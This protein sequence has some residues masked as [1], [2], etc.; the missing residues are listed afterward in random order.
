[1]NWR[2]GRYFVPPTDIIELTDRL[3]VMI[4]IA[5]M[6]SDDF[7][8]TQ[9]NRTLIVSGVRRRDISEFTTYHQLEIGYGY[10]RVEVNLPWLPDAEQI[11]ATYRDGI[12]EVALPRRADRQIPVVDVGAKEGLDGTA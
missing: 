7:N 6:S 12:L 11:E 8:I 9:V 1:M 2:T 3:L 5:G 10:F 4:E